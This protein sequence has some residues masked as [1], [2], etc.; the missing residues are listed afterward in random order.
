MAIGYS[1]NPIKTIDNVGLTYFQI[2]FGIR[3]IAQRI[4]SKTEIHLKKNQ[5]ITFLAYICIFGSYR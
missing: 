3:I 1:V 4:P 5:I 2:E